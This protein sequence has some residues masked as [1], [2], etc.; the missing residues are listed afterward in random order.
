MLMR[1]ARPH[2]RLPF[3]EI[4]IWV[5][6]LALLEGIDCSDHSEIWCYTIDG[7]YSEFLIRNEKEA[8]RRSEEKLFTE[9]RDLARKYTRM[10]I[11]QKDFAL[12][13]TLAECQGY[14][15]GVADERKAV[16]KVARKALS[17]MKVL[18]F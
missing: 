5:D 16:G 11:E 9:H 14:W 15:E 3:I 7:Y 13:M 4:G 10:A 6:Q 8:I 17:T 2:P 12:A 1:D 18:T